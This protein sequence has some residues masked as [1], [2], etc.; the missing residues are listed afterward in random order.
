MFQT[1]I[2]ECYLFLLNKI[3][4]NRLKKARVVYIASFSANDGGLIEALATKYKQEFIL[5]HTANFQ[6][7]VRLQETIETKVYTPKSLFLEKNF[8]YLRQAEVIVIDNYFAELSLLPKE[9]KIIQI[10]HALGAIKTFGWEDPMTTTR[11]ARAKKRFQKVY[12]SMDVV[13]VASDKMAQIFQKSYALRPSKFQYFG[14]LKLAEQLKQKE[15]II[16][17]KGSKGRTLYAPTYRSSEVQMKQVLSQAFCAFKELKNE[18]FYLRLHPSVQV[19]SLALP[20]NVYLWTSEM[21]PLNEKDI[22]I[23]DY[24]ATSFEQLVLYPE[25]SIYFFCPDYAQYAK[26]PGIQSDFLTWCFGPIAYSA[27]QLV[28]QLIKK[29]ANNYQTKRY[30]AKSQWFQYNQV[31]PLKKILKL[32]EEWL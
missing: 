31:D 16:L 12:D 15:P 28:E 10:W 8:Q 2:K 6:V 21:P 30:L 14:H 25:A 11:D 5:F 23:T 32:I 4:V 9:I 13:V 26:D 7:P 24:S 20:E 1:M 18:T 27:E 19:K 22:L 17:E 3:K 29:E